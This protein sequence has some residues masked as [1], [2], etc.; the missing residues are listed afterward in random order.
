MKYKVGDRVKIIDK[1]KPYERCKQN[2]CGLMD[3][4]LGT[5][6]TIKKIDGEYYIMEEDAGTRTD[7]WNDHWYW[8]EH[9]IAGLANNTSEIDNQLFYSML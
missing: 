7:G 9:C 6:M 5:V 2:N 4:W 8:N 1:W 3:R